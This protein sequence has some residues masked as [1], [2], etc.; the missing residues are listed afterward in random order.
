MSVTYLTAVKYY[1][2]RSAGG[3]ESVVKVNDDSFS[4]SGTS[5]LF[6]RNSLLLLYM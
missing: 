6:R 5:K 1:E 4:N 2:T 3:L